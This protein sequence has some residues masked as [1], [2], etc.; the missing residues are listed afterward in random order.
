L[1]ERVSEREIVHWNLCAVTHWEG[2]G[3]SGLL[4]S[5]DCPRYC[6]HSERWA[7]FFLF[8]MKITGEVTGTVTQKTK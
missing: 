5:E 1:K 6:A 7:V 8:F 4:A 3:E 2:E